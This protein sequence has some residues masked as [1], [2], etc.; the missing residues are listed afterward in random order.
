MPRGHTRGATLLEEIVNLWGSRAGG[1]ALRAGIAREFL[2]SFSFTR[3]L[4]VSVVTNAR[5]HTNSKLETRQHRRQRVRQRLHHAIYSTINLALL[6]TRRS[7]TTPDAHTASSRGLQHQP[8]LC[9]L[10]NSQKGVRRCFLACACKISFRRA[11]KISFG[12]DPHR[13]AAECTV[14]YTP[15]ACARSPA[16]RSISASTA[17]T[18]RNSRTCRGLSSS[19]RSPARTE[20]SL[21]FRQSR[22]QHFQAKLTA[23]S[24][25][26]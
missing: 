12:R 4:C 24:L 16:R 6:R 10:D 22:S 23:S 9:Y 18:C 1:C 15:Q 19:R 25:C 20:Y 3:E 17:Y 13:G 5:R 7:H 21:R 26:R 8:M 2:H 14:V 11:Y